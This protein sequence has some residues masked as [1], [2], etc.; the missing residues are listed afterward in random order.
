MDR[1]SLWTAQTCLSVRKVDNHFFDR[2]LIFLLFIFCMSSVL[3]TVSKALLAYIV[4]RS[5]WCAG[6]WFVQAFVYVLCDCRGKCCC[7]ALGSKAVFG[8]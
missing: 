3:G 7:G 8:G 1:V 4:A 5:V 2:V 6:F